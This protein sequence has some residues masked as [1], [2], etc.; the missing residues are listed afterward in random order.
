MKKITR[1]AS[2]ECLWFH[3]CCWRQL[4]CTGLFNKTCIRAIIPKVPLHHYTTVIHLIH[5]RWAPQTINVSITV[6]RS[7]IVFCRIGGLGH[8]RSRVTFRKFTGNVIG[9]MLGLGFWTW[10]SRIR[11]MYTWMTTT[12]ANVYRFMILIQSY[13]HCSDKTTHYKSN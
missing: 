8:F 13:W 11:C 12:N 3:S 2:V 9:F 1:L 7:Q 10:A 6:A 5:S 4:N